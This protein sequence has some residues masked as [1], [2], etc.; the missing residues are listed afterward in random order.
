MGWWIEIFQTNLRKPCHWLL[1]MR[2]VSGRPAHLPGPSPSSGV[3]GTSPSWVSDPGHLPCP[4]SGDHHKEGDF[5]IFIQSRIVF[6]TNLGALSSSAGTTG[7]S[8]TCPEQSWSPVLGW[9]SWVSTAKTDRL[10]LSELSVPGETQPHVNTAARGDREECLGERS[11]QFGTWRGHWVTSSMMTQKSLSEKLTFKHDPNT[12][13]CKDQKK[14]HFRG[15]GLPSE[16]P[17]VW[18]EPASVEEE[19]GGQRGQA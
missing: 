18:S 11:G 16:S 17:T 3:T 6:R 1:G 9:P 15:R 19:R 4:S 14:E 2:R 8:R 10:L 13:T 7:V 5:I 12:L